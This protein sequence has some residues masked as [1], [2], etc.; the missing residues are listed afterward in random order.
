VNLIYGGDIFSNACK[1]ISVDR[2]EVQK[3]LDA[4]KL[5]MKSRG[6]DLYEDF[7]IWDTGATEIASDSAEMPYSESP[8]YGA[9]SP[10]KINSIST[11]GKSR[12]TQ[13]I[14][15][16]GRKHTKTDGTAAWRNNNPGNIEYGDFAK[17]NGAIGTD[18]RFAIFPD[19]ATGR[20]A[21][22]SL[23]Q[24]NKYR[25]LS[26]ADAV[27]RYA[28][29]HENDTEAYRAALSRNTGIALDKKMGQ[30]SDAEM[31]RVVK[32]IQRIEGWKQGKETIG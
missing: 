30:L 23:L 3:L 10:Q 16:D 27:K 29:P 7:D 13:F 25:N 12:T 5:A 21:I 32:E 15:S 31:E 6:G 1:I 9:G 4:R 18:G 2:A 14:G 19:E 24:T 26:M 28:P 20:R 11:G 8:V 22:A 17:R